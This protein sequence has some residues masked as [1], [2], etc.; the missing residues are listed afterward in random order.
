MIQAEVPASVF[1]ARGMIAKLPP[2]QCCFP[3]LDWVEPDSIDHDREI[4]AL[5]VHSRALFFFFPVFVC[6]FDSVLHVFS[7]DGAW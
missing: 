6:F 3:R 2:E 7:V 1:N 4:E 5:Q